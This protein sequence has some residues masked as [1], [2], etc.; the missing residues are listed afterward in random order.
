[1]HLFLDQCS[2]AERSGQEWRARK[3]RGIELL[4]EREEGRGS[5]LPAV[6]GDVASGKDEAVGC[7]AGKPADMTDCMLDEAR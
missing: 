2:R 4:R 6:M 7:R 1:M 5:E 3:W